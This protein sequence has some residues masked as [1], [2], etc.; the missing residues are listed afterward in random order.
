[1]LYTASRLNY[2]RLKTIALQPTYH[3][4]QILL[5]YISKKGARKQL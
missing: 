4:K 3:P 5:T 2:D 1:M